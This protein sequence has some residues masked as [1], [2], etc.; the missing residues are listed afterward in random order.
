[1]TLV[2]TVDVTKIGAVSHRTHRR[3]R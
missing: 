1:M 3:I 2:S